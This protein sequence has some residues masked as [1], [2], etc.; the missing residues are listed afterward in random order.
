M[1]EDNRR[2]NGILDLWY[3]DLL[4][5]A[6]RRRSSVRGGLG[7]SAPSVPFQRTEG[8]SMSIP[9][10]DARERRIVEAAT[11]FRYGQPTQLQDAEV[12]LQLDAARQDHTFCPA[13]YWNERDVQFVVCKTA[14]KRYRSY[15]FYAE[16]A[17]YR[18]GEKDY[19][20]LEDC[21]RNLL[22]LQTDHERIRKGVFSGATGEDLGDDDYLGPI[23]I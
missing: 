16:D 17:Q 11:V 10:F 14:E 9:G 7:V 13:V 20:V 22:Q 18:I 12:E 8:Y 1:A 19:E 5:C 3:I 2:R 6:K 21:V 15:F 23:I 4:T